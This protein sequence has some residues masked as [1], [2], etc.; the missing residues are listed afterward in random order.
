MTSQNYNRIQVVY[1]REHR[2]YLYGAVHIVDGDLNNQWWEKPFVISKQRPGGGEVVYGTVTR[3]LEKIVSQIDRLRRFQSEAQAKLDAVGITPQQDS[4]LPRS[5]MADRILDEQDELVEDVL[6]AVSVNVRILSEI[7]RK[8]LERSRVNVYDYDDRRVGRIKLSGIADL[9]VHNRYIMVKDQ[10]VVDLISD[11]KFM[12]EKPQMG[13]KINA[14]EYFSE[15]EKVVD[16]IT[17]KDLVTKLRGLTKRLSASS[18]IKNIIFLTQNLYTLGGSIVGSDITIDAGPLKTIFDR[19]ATDYLE[20]TYPQTAVGITVPVSVA[21]STPRF[22]L[23][24]E[25]DQKRIRIET[26]VNG[27]RETLVMG[28]EDFFREVARAYGNRKLRPERR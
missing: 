26:Q 28:Y 24:P 6:M 17:V 7:F 23:E 15:V 5:D 10:Y 27:S 20:R 21:F 16:S 9:L 1:D 19:V 2:P 22:C 18:N 3:T 4:V 14:L 25:L 11:E 12:A 13:L 8:K